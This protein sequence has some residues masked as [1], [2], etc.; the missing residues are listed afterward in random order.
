MKVARAVANYINDPLTAYNTL[1][2]Y[3]DSKEYKT[4]LLY[5]SRMLMNDSNI[6]QAIAD[7]LGIEPS[8]LES[9]VS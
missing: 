4:A 6:V 3:K 8:E 9:P 1:I 7:E 2:E 5:L